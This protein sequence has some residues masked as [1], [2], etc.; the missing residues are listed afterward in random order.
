MPPSKNQ[1][2]RL[3]EQMRS[4]ITERNAALGKVSFKNL[5]ELD[6][7]IKRLDEQINSGL[8]K[9]VD[10]K[11]ALNESN[12]LKR[13]RKN[14]AQFD[15]QKKDID[16]LRAKI[17]ET[18]DGMKD[19][20]F[21]SL[22]DQWNKL[23]TELSA[24]DAEQDE[25]YKGL[26]GLRDERT[27]LHNES[28]TKYS[29][30][31]KIKN[32]YYS[33]RNAFVAYEREAKQKAWERKQAEQERIARERKKER[34]QKMLAEAA[35]PAYMDEIRRASS[36]LRFFDPSQP[37]EKTPLLADSGL[38][39]QA[40]RKVDDSGLKGIKLVRKEDRE[41]EYLPPVKKGK[42]SKKGGAAP[43]AR[44]ARAITAR[45]P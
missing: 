32:E 42:K 26:S 35:D 31:Q 44:R 14:F 4:R 13:L 36:L 7:E 43:A 40:T 34:A 37:V 9:L 38:G 20:E 30:M 8:M 5:E 3:E 15:S 16:S 25:A 21:D 45:R 6:R 27:K 24:I 2:K 29:A 12:S 41:D 1:V 17:Q 19:P 10:E 22:S 23:K 33:Q 39:A 11:K 28:Q 18:K